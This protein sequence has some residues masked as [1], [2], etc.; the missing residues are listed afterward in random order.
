MA[1]VKQK[2]TDLLPMNYRFFLLLIV[3]LLSF[4]FL[5]KKQTSIENR[6]QVVE[7]V[8]ADSAKLIAENTK[9]TVM[10][11]CKLFYESLDATKYDMPNYESF[12]KAFEG[13]NLLQQQGKI[14]NE[15]LTIVDF[16]LASTQERM[17]VIDMQTQKIVLQT[18]VAHGRNSGD[19]YATKF[20]N[21]AESFQSS[22]GFYLTGEV[23]QGK[24]GT[25]LRLDGLEY[26]INDNAR[27]R[28]VVVHGADYVSKEI[29]K[30]QG[31]LGRSY[32]C[33]AVSN[34]VSNK[35]I[36]LIKNK[37]VLFIYH[38]SRSYAAK[39]KLVS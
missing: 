7:K 10:E 30:Q 20:S 11:K 8:V 35:L 31:R 4:G 3:C 5:P 32:G 15:T 36:Q 19:N 16:S 18:L 29:I 38:P 12:T 25:S 21:T 9:V 26:G 1:L 23:Y 37:S 17:W 28:A 39:S 14:K 33:P 22:L 13:Y 2:I 27:E 24:H 6:K 34:T